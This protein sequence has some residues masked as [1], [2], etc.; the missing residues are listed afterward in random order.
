M[1]RGAPLQFD[2]DEAL[3]R[4]MTLFWEKGYEATS[5][6]DLLE[7]MQIGRQSLYN[8]FGDK[9]SLFE[10]ALSHYV[11]TRIEALKEVLES[12]PTPL[13][14]VRRAL[15]FYEQQVTSGSCLGCMLAN[16]VAESGAFEDKENIDELL[17]SK[18]RSKETMFRNCLERAKAAGELSDDAN[19]LA[20]ARAIV[21]MAFGTTVL[22]R[23][24]TPKAMNR[25][26][27]AMT[28]RLLDSYS[29]ETT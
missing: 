27:I 18:I 9:R 24:G 6:S 1:P 11:S 23:V 19:P 17:R 20:L 3:E 5:L 26:V 15:K 21:S 4:A 16:S 10:E 2:R 13:T 22:S 8:T 14:G 7:H 25:D 28:L 12:G 29:I